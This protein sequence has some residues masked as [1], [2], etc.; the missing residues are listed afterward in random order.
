M[1]FWAKLSA[2]IE[3]RDSLLCVGLDPHPGQIPAQYG[4][5]GAFMRA[6]VEQTADLACVFKPNIAF[7]EA[8]G[9]EGLDTLQEIL[10]AIPD[11]VPVILDGKRND[12]ASTATA[13]AIGAF[14]RLGA[15][16]LTVNPYLGSDG[17]APFM[18]YA[19]RGIFVLCKTSNPGA[20]EIQDWSQHGVPLYRHVAEL[21][22]QWSQGGEIG[23][24]IGATYRRSG[25]DQQLVARD[26]LRAGS[27][28]G[29]A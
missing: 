20:G 14:D 7:Y 2:S 24:V 10:E 22:N 16:A 8:L 12:I 26:H 27:S 1:D 19:D 3:K 4:S 6:I 23:L 29:S 15:D 21:A 17:V 9:P 25:R 13:Y 28:P 5:V 11:D 18:A